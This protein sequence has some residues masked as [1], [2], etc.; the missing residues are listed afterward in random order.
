MYRREI[1]RATL[2]QGEEG[3]REGGR[4]REGGGG[5]DEDEDEREVKEQAQ[6]ELRGRRG[7]DH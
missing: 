7:E 3:G 4:G 5:K 1:T 2:V 6:H